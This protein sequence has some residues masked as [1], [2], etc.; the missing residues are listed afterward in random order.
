MR[1]PGMATTTRASMLSVL[2]CA[3]RGKEFR[4][5]LARRGTERVGEKRTREETAAQA[6]GEKRR[7]TERSVTE[8]RALEVD[9][10]GHTTTTETTAQGE[11][12]GE[13]GE[14]SVAGTGVGS[15]ASATRSD[16]RTEPAA[17]EKRARHEIAHGSNSSHD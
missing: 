8:E 4:E 14:A 10:G 5:R 16:A 13:E 1:A 11:L 2:R 3:Q 6:E 17:G 15:G 9:V 7:R 12:H